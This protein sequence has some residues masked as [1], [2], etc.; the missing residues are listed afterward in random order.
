[1]EGNKRTLSLLVV[2]VAV[3][4]LY[5]ITT[6]LMSPEGEGEPASTEQA[7]GGEGAEDASAEDAAED[8]GEAQAAALSEEERE[9]RR[10]L[11][12]IATEHYRATVDNLAGGVTE[13]RLT[14]DPRFTDQETGAPIDV[15]TTDR[16]EFAALR[17]QLGEGVIPDDAIWALEQVSER[18]VRLTWEGEHY[19]VV[20]SLRAGEG[21]YQ[22]WSTTR[23]VNT[24][25]HARTTRLEM[26]A[27]HYVTREQ[28]SGGL[29]VSRSSYISQGVC[30]WDEETE[31]KDRDSLV[32]DGAHGY[33]SGDV[34]VAALENVYFTQAMAAHDQLAARCALYG[35]NRG[36]TLD[37]PHGT[38][39]EAR[40]LYPWVEIDPGDEVTYQ[41]LAYLGPKDR[42]A[43]NLAGHE[44]PEMVDLGFFALIARQLARFLSFIHQFV[45]NWGLAIIL[46]TL[47]IRLTLFPLTNLSFKSMARMRRLKPEIDRINELYKDDAEKKGAAVM[48]L[49]RKHKINPLS[50]CLPSLLQLPVWWAL[51]TSLSTN[52]ELYHMP[53]ALWW[54][55]LSSPDPFY[56]LPVMLGALMHLQQRLSPTSM[57]PTQAKMMMYFM[58]IMITVFMLFLPSGL[59]LYMLTNS[60]LGIGQQKLNEYR[61]SKEAPLETSEDDDDGGSDDGEDA[62]ETERKSTKRRPKRKRR[63]RRGRA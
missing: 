33:G 20:R 50:G 12:T 25:D 63:V 49:Y 52:I 1:M 5:F 42:G 37:D 35:S 4:A 45:P 19:R 26:G 54:T 40:L 59:C 8:A 7:E 60:A 43:L 30:V 47:I 22:V 44:L 28:E 16:E 32:E 27:W 53:F 21:P 36:G 24:A 39:F 15:V 58:P 56:V 55:D 14:G 9:A 18:E 3:G 51:Y 17:I 46:L 48:E 41:T 13:L 38:L 62:G 57:D 11:G 29:F 2:A 23:I 61:L 6:Q 34:H 31:R 10:E